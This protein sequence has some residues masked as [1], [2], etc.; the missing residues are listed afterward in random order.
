[1]NNEDSRAKGKRINRGHV[2]NI[3][4]S[5]TDTHTLTLLQKERD[6]GSFIPVEGHTHTNLDRQR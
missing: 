2:D 3:K 4:R 6:A 1:M 5:K